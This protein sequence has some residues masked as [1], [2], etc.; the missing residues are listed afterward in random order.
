MKIQF[1]Y[2]GE[3][4]ILAAGLFLA[5][6]AISKGIVKFKELD[7]TVTA[8]GLSEK[9]VKADKAIWPLKFKELN[10]SPADLYNTIEKD[11]RII[12]EFLKSNGISDEEITQAPPTIV[13]QQANM[14]Y[15]SEQVRYR[16]KANCVV[17]VVSRNVDLVRKVVS[18]QA[19]LMRQ[20]VTIVGNEYDESSCVSYEFT[21]LNEIKPEMIAEATKNARKTAERF[22]EDSGSELGKIRTASQGQFSIEDRDQN[23][24]W[25]KNVR[26]VT[27]VDYYLKD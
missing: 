21:A 16:Y 20:G 15:S 2:W 8:K 6:G 14:S 12:V 24:P 4:L 17:T 3:A 22:A 7:R 27:T 13:D 26:V 25:L 19:E 23:T 10:N 18:K 1:K 11:T 9:E 5:G